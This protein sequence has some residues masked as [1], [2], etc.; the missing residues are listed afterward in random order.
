MKVSDFDFIL[1]EDRIALHPL[2][3]RDAAK[4][5]HISSQ[6][7]ESS[8]TD[9]LF[10]ELPELLNAGDVLVL[11]DSRVIPARLFGKRGEA[12]VEILLH[13]PLQGNDEI[14]WRVFLRPGKR[15]KINDTIVIDEHLT[16][17]VLEKYETGEA[18]LRFDAA[19]NKAFYDILQQVGHMPLP[20]YIKRNDEA[21]DKNDYQTVYADAPGSVAAPT[22]GLHFTPELL[23]RCSDKCIDICRLTLHVGAGTFQPVKAEDTDDHVMHS[24]WAAIS[25]DTAYTINKARKE[26]GKIVAVGTTALRTLESAAEPDGTIRPFSGETD[27]FITPGYRF[28]AVDRLITN[29]HLPKST[30][31][32]LVSAFCGTERM[33]QAYQY[34]IDHD[35]RFY[36]YGDACLL[37]R[38]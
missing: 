19:D 9:R 15:I 1:P 33:K 11:N 7:P 6:S 13:K 8:F 31:F 10:Y 4:L 3:P 38:S 2:E 5:L 22:A 25:P 36:S 30:L 14:S 24:E 32:M 21:I 20:P 37:E 27:I 28:K 23:K 12:K 29:F 35:Y 17:T 34:A 18:L 26:G 16:A